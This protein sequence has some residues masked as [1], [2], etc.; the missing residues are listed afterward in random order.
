MLLL[1]WSCT[2]VSQNQEEETVGRHRNRAAN[3]KEYL[4][5]P[6]VL[7]R[8]EEEALPGGGE[9]PGFASHKVEDRF[10]WKPFMNSC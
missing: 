10:F 2:I 8:G 9:M 4:E 1:L 6:A 3:V 7:E 5:I